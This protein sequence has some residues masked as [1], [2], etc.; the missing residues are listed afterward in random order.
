MTLLVT[1][2]VGIISGILGGT[3]IFGIINKLLY[4]KNT[5]IISHEE[6]IVVSDLVNE[7]HIKNIGKEDRI[8]K[9]IDSKKEQKKYLSLENRE[10]DKKVAVKL[11]EDIIALYTLLNLIKQAES[12]KQKRKIASINSLQERLDKIKNPE[13]SDVAKEMAQGVVLKESNSNIKEDS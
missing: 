4:N 13:P 10:I 1:A 2:A 11:E 9:L 7:Y 8:L 5:D 6:Q 12:E 3:I